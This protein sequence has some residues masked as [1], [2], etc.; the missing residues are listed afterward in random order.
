MYLKYDRIAS[1][2]DEMT[3]W[4]HDI[5][6]YP[7][8]AYDEHRTA[9]LVSELLAGFGCEVTT[10]I[11]K[12]GVVG[13]LRFGSSKKSIAL[14]ADMDALPILEKNTFEYRSVHTGKMHACGH[15]G[16][17]AMLLGAAKY[18]GEVKNF[19]G[20][21]HFIFQPAEEGAGGAEAMINDGLFNRFDAD[22]VYGMHNWPGI[23]AGEFAIC[24]GAMM[25]A[26]DK[27]DVH[28][29]GKG[30]HASMP[31]K[32]INSI[33]VGTEV[34]R[35]LQ[36][37][38]S[39]VDPAIISTL[40]ITKFESGDAY[41]VIPES[42][43]MRGSVRSLNE[44][45]RQLF[46]ENAAK[47]VEQV[48]GSWE[49]HCELKYYFGTPALLN[50]SAQTQKAIGVAKDL[51]GAKNVNGAIKPIM[52]SEDFACMLQKKPGAYI[53]IGNGIET[54]AGG[55]QGAC[56]I[57]NSKYDFNDDILVLG[58]SYWVRLTEKLLGRV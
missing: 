12:T 10:G 37:F 47:I 40:A 11:G 43:H 3:A 44:E 45:S 4:R 25:A 8:L 16:H 35:A 52:A 55:G 24:S 14:R 20:T 41:N 48:G 7:E 17:T 58:A 22:E 53:L 57:H 6:R 19:D 29:S 50:S 2:N 46:F 31:D 34:V 51:V 39:K 49:A 21:V 30:G 13:T 33:L 26:S 18:L 9:N 27:F 56:I 36:S 54:E 32:C 23:A 28:V 15:D 1:F 42:A 38:F 5:H